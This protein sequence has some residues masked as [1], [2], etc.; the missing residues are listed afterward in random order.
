M[1]WLT[2]W[3]YQKSISLSRTSGAVSNHQMKLTVYYGSGTDSTGVVYCDSLCK[4]DFSDIRITTSD[5]TTLLDI[6]MES[7]TDSNNAVFWIEF[8]SI[9]T[10][11]TTFY[12]YCGNSGAATVSNGTNTF[13]LFENFE[14][15][16][17]GDNISTSGGSVVWTLTQGVATLDTSKFFSGSK[18]AKFTGATTIPIYTIPIANSSNIAIRMRFYKNAAVANGPN[19]MQGNGTRT[20][21]FYYAADQKLH[22]SDGSD[23]GTTATCTA[24]AWQLLEINNFNF[25]A[26]TCSIYLNGASHYNIPN[27]ATDATNNNVLRIINAGADSAKNVWFDDIIVRDWLSTEPTWDSWGQWVEQFIPFVPLVSGDDGYTTFQ[28]YTGKTFVNF[29]NFLNIGWGSYTLQFQEYVYS[30]V[31]FPNVTI[32]KTIPLDSVILKLYQH[33][34]TDRADWITLRIY[35]N[36][37]ANAIAPTSGNEQ[38]ALALTASY[39]DWTIATSAVGGY[40]YVSPNL[41]SALQEV[42]NNNDWVSGNALQIVIKFTEASASTL[43]ILQVYA[44]DDQSALQPKLYITAVSSP[45]RMRMGM[46]KIDPRQIGHVTI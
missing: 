19:L 37:I 10:T 15:G 22:Y 29:N 33:V 26:K 28:A 32:S 11:A 27:M 18:S 2:G 39:V 41:K 30:F 25:S 38:V 9:G 31:R 5:G 14:W 20:W 21:N 12:I 35:F 6:W 42:L 16:N 4:T 40:E 44:N 34:Q 1:A 8:N 3:T 43:A 24:D 7:K 45:D 13:I 23:H 17:N 36:S 46:L